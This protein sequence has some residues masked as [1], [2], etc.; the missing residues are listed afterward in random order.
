[1][2]EIKEEKKTEFQGAI[3]LDAILAATSGKTTEGS[4][5][6]KQAPIK[7]EP[8]KTEE[9]KEEVKPETTPGTPV[10]K[11]ETPLKETPKETPAE[12]A[13]T[14]TETESFKTAK[15]LIELGLLADFS[16]KTSDEDENG[17]PVSEFTSMTEDNLKEIVK[18]HKE[19]KDEEISSKYL[20]K[21]DLKEHQLKVFEIL[22]NGGDL[23]Q[24]AES[25]E[26]AL[27]RP[28]EGF[29]MEEQQRQ[30]D[31]RYTD[32][33][34]SKGLDHESAITIIDK[35]VKSGKLKEKALETFDLYR[36]AHSQYIDDILEQQ[37]K[38]KEFKDLN[39]REN[40]KSL[41]AKLK[42]S[43]LKE[44]V[45][46]KVASEYGKK[47]DNGDYALIDKLREALD[48]PEE[49]HELILH[50]ADKKLFNETFKIKASQETQKT[51]VRLASGA[52]S[53]SGKQST[54]ATDTEA[55]APWLVA[56]KIHN[57]NNKNN[58]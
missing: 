45:Y 14:S 19:D 46:K 11:E 25:P 26:K 27:E 44:S 54:K 18:I 53:K 56:A 20:P 12:A 10:S 42:E 15:K 57:E 51:I 33:V 29:D 41:T 17:T 55:K 49:N 9:I 1:M 31:V 32:L 35:E 8:K 16:I 22:S 43:G 4:G 36:S 3:S 37:K 34:H 48:S 39:F 47:N 24:V 6:K 21:G 58:K 23:S 50:L 28:F 2:T 7:E 38:E 40:K 30:I 13:A 52:A 5:E